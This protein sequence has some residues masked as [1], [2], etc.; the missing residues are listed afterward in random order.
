MAE[1]LGP[2]TKTKTA[3]SEGPK[4]AGELPGV[5]PGKFAMGVNGIRNTAG[6]GKKTAQAC[7]C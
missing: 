3:S 5:G 6:E 2:M 1:V 7:D 4:G